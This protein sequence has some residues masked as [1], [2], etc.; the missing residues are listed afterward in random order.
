MKLCIGQGKAGLKR[1]RSDP[2]NQTINP[3]SELSQNIPGK[4]KIEIGKTK[5]EHSKDQT[6]IINNADTGIAH[7]KPLI[8]D[9]PFHLGPT[10]SPPPKLIRSN[11]PRSQESSQSSSSVENINP[12]INLDFEENS[13]FQEGVVSE[14]FQRPDK[15]SKTQKN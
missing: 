3:P 15:S 12:D 1:K 10:Y 4:T 5:L 11:V 7:S 9:V 6:H 2:I 8:P 14:T 13:P